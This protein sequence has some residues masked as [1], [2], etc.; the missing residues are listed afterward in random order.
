MGVEII[1]VPKGWKHPHDDDGEPV[2]GGHL[3][4]LYEIDDGEKSCYQLYENV[5]EGTPISGVFDSKSELVVWLTEH[6]MQADK[7][8]LLLEFGHAPSFTI[9]TT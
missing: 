2:P 3:E 7:L 8:A 5:S 4:L 6:G 1:K 9:K